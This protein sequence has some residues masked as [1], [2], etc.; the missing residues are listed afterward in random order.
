[1][2]GYCQCLFNPVFKIYV[3]ILPCKTFPILY[4]FITFSFLFFFLGGWAQPDTSL[5]NFHFPF[6]KLP[7]CTCECKLLK[8]RL[9]TMGVSPI[10]CII[11]SRSPGK[12]PLTEDLLH[13]HYQMRNHSQFNIL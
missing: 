5:S 2:H 1:M 9:S 7:E 12:V 4:V 11:I 13:R 8:Q 6:L 10:P 3:T